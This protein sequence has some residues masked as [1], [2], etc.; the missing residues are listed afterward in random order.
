MSNI[1]KHAR[2]RVRCV[3]FALIAAG[4]LGFALASKAADDTAGAT[5]FE[6]PRDTTPDKAKSFDAPSRA[7]EDKLAGAPG[8][9]SKPSGSILRCWQGGQMI[10]EGRGYGPLPSSQVA[11][12]LKQADGSPGRTQVID[13]Y[14]GLCVLEVPK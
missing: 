8:R 1:N 11:A 9:L 12:D 2:R 5:K 13:L 3:A 10:F 14:E 6:L 7:Y 4:P